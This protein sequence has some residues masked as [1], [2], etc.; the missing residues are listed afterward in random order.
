MRIS[1][2][3]IKATIASH[4]RYQRQYHFVALEG[5]CQLQSFN[6]YGQ[7]DVLA[8]TPDRY[9]IEVE[10]KTSIADFRKDGRKLKHK[11]FRD[12][13]DRYPT[14]YFY[15]AVPRV[16]ANQ[17]SLLCDQLYPYAG[18]LGTDGHG[19]ADVNYYRTAR[20][21]AG[22]RLTFKQILYMVRA[23]SAT[24][25]RLAEALVDCKKTSQRKE[26]P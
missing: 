7:A 14:K 25:C 23:Q 20:R 12:G 8:V 4:F 18:V 11:A 9:L 5:N 2:D 21:L 19:W 1:S 6:D 13:S 17:V 15:F 3:A 16:L 26:E 22:Q 24:I 10:V